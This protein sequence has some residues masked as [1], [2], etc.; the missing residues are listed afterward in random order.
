[1]ED[2]GQAENTIVIYLSDHGEYAAAHGMM[3]EKW[4]AAYEEALHVPLVVQLPRRTSEDAPMRQ[5]DAVTSHIDILPTILGLAGVHERQRDEIADRLAGRRPLPPLPGANLAPLIHG[6][7]DVVRDPDGR[8]REGVLFITDDEITEPLPPSYDRR[9]QN[10]YEQFAVY[11]AAVE[12]VRTGSMGK[13]PVPDLAPGPV[14]QPNHVRCVR[15][16]KQKLA[17]YFDP[18]GQRPQEW[19]M[20]DLAKD[21]NEECNLLQVHGTPPVARTELPP[22]TT[23]AAVQREADH[24]ASLLAELERRNL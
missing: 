13:G 3:M 1:V 17:R 15:T 21:P 11:E 23:R 14:R 7:T 4:H 9:E 18:S 8:E 5:I 22:W 19:E 6:V 10:S 20:Y 24:L 2:S 16:G 12:A